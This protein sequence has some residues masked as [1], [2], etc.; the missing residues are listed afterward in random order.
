MNDR[1][2]PNRPLIGVG[3]VIVKD[4]N[5]LLARRGQEPAMGQWSIPGGLVKV[6]EELH[7][8]LRR[9]ILEETGLSI[10]VGPVV[11]VLSRILYDAEGKVKFHFVIIDYLCTNPTGEDA[12]STDVLEICWASPDS[13]EEYQL[14]PLT[15]QVIGKAFVVWRENHLP[16]E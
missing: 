14:K 3:G 9:E 2:Y 15:L 12:A 16:Q 8:A 4:G 10:T 13:L 5:V 6:G 1:E 7:D 11:E